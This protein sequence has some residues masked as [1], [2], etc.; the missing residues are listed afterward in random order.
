MFH[1]DFH[2]MRYELGIEEVLDYSFRWEFQG[3]GTIH[4]H[5]IAWVKFRDGVEPRQ[6]DGRSNQSDAKSDLL[7]HLESA[8]N[9]SI[10]VQCGDGSAVLLRYVAGYVTKASDALTFKQ[11]EYLQEGSTSTWRSVYRLLCKKAPLLHEMT[12]EFA[13]GLMMEASFRGSTVYAPLPGYQ[14]RA[15]EHGREAPP[16]RRGESDEKKYNKNSSQA[17]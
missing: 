17:M 8:F 4:V 11:K 6:L 7:R 10:D 5:A 1:S 14:Q 9:A 13:C 16:P 12:M 3:R 2:K 15:E